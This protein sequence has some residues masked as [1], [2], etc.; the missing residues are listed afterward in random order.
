[1]QPSL[2]E[3]FTALEIANTRAHALAQKHPEHEDV[4]RKFMKHLLQRLG[5]H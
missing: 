4:L 5:L 3:I 1:M 2:D